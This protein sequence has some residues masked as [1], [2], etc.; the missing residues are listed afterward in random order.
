MAA[1]S[2]ENAETAIPPGLPDPGIHVLDR[3]TNSYRKASSSRPTSYETHS[4]VSQTQLEGYHPIKHALQIFTDASI[5]GWGAHLDERTARG[6]WFPLGSKLHIKYLELKAVFQTLKEFQDLCSNKIVLVATD[7]TT[8][9]SYI[10]GWRH[11]VGPTWCP[12]MENLDLVYQETSDS[13]A[14]HIPGR[15]NVVADKLSRL[16]Q[17][18]QTEWFLLPEVFHSMQQVTPAQNRLI[19]HEVQQQVA[20]V[21][22]T[23]IRSPGHSSGCGQSTRV[24]SESIH[25]PTI[26]HIGQVVEKLQ[27]SP[28]KRVIL[29]APGWPNMP[30]FWDLVAMSSQIPLSLP[31]LPNLLTAIQSDPSQKSDK[32]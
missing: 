1:P 32:S 13:K 14:R 26:S 3:F 21:W 30:W 28:C 7:N 29:I 25:L 17:T 2:R 15:L 6:T 9:V 18:I 16:G 24:G 23:S 12:T 20:S 8:V 4:V 27:D 31:N 11:E 22:V 19:Y 10:K 5:E